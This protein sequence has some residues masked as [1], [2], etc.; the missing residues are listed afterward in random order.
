MALYY[1]NYEN[2]DEIHALLLLLTTL[3]NKV[4]IIWDE[5]IKELLF[6][7]VN[8]QMSSQIVLIIND[9]EELDFNLFQNEKIKLDISHNECLD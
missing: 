3:I 5:E 1:N 6:S 2:L 4:I 9:T 7:L 8:Q